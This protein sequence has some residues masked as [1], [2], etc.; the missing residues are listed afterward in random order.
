MTLQ[1]GP[2]LTEGQEGEQLWCIPRWH[3]EQ[4]TMDP[5]VKLILPLFLERMALFTVGWTSPWQPQ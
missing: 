5:E 3:T 1:A 2:Q 4:V